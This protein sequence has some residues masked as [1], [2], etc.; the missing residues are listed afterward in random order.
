MPAAGSQVCTYFR[1]SN[2]KN[3]NA[4]ATATSVSAAD[5][6]AAGVSGWSQVAVFAFPTIKIVTQGAAAT[7]VQGI[8]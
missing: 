8:A 6:P 3:R 2:R 7:N 1:F 5:V 4:G